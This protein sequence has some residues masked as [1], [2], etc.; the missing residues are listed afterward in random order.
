MNKSLLFKKAHKLTRLTIQKGYC[1][2]ATFAACL[3]L[4]TANTKVNKS[5]AL[6][7]D[8]NKPDSKE[9]VTVNYTSFNNKDCIAINHN[10]DE[11]SRT[12]LSYKDNIKP[13]NFIGFM[14]TNIIVVTLVIFTFNYLI[15]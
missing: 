3:K 11:P 5:V 8:Y 6:V 7:G 9:Y 14:V 12:R 2:R 13:I 10:N 1:Y 4:I 15:K